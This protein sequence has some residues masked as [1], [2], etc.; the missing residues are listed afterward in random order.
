MLPLLRAAFAAADRGWPVFPLVPYRKRPAITGWPRA[1]SIDAEVLTAWWR[2]APY[3]VGIACGPA[4]LLVVDLDGPGQPTHDWAG[5]ADGHA[6]F[7]ELARRSNATV[8]P[9]LTVAT[10]SRGEHR[11]YAVEQ[12][13]P[14]R[15]TAGSLG[16]HVDTRGVGGYVVAAGSV[17]QVDGPHRP[18][19]VL[20]PTDPAP[21][22]D[23]LAALLAP[24]PAPIVPPRIRVRSSYVE[25]AVA[26]EVALVCRARPGTRNTVV[27]RAAVSLGTLVA[28]GVL[29]ETEAREVLI[30]ACT[31]HIGLDGFT[32]AEAERAVING[33]RYGLR[34]PRRFASRTR[35]AA[36]G[37]V[38]PRRPKVGTAGPGERR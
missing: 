24:I 30:A 16:W 20:D 29:D 37:P 2:Q 19:R 8:E 32:T 26:N 36:G 38:S 27:F 17:L 13:Q 5:A 7:T 21:L 4:G 23:W 28:A 10:P 15:S 25:T 1:A 12:G 9:T 35:R 14:A 31:V 22:P 18:Y 34:R 11:Y 33:L 3:N 6:V